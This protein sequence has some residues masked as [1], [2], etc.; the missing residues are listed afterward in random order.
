LR[1]ADSK[2]CRLGTPENGHPGFLFSCKYR[3]PDAYIYMNMGIPMP[4]S[5]VN[6]GIPL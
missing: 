2:E 3:H 5:T 4:I 1:H 6:M